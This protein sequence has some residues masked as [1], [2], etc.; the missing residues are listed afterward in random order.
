MLIQVHNLSQH[1]F[2]GHLL[3]SV[4]LSDPTP[5]DTRAAVADVE[6]ACTLY[7]VFGVFR[8][9]GMLIQFHRVL[10]LSAGGLYSPKRASLLRLRGTLMQ[11]SLIHI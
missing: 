11:L 6:M 4:W 10:L 1:E 3:P 2:Q 9:R 7:S 8:P 5:R